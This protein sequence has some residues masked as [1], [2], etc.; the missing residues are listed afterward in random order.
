VAEHHL[1]AAPTQSRWNRQ[2]QPRLRIAPGDTVHI[3]CEDSSG[4]QVRPGTT[5][6]EFLK[7]DRDHI[8]ALTGPIFVEGAEVG[9]V[10]QVDVLDVAHKGWGRSSSISGLGFLKERFAEPYLFHGG[11]KV[12]RAARWI[13][14]C[15]RCVL[16][17]ELWAWRLQRTENSARDHRKLCRKHGCARAAARYCTSPC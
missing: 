6:E 17:A 10:L 13:L 14:R 9:D 5:V 3:E 2:L 1:S 7:I 12:R 11:W 15:C 4:S 16:F 8:Q